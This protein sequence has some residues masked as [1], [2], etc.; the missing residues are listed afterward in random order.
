[1]GKVKIRWKA[2]EING[3]HPKTLSGKCNYKKYIYYKKYVSGDQYRRISAENFILQANYGIIPFELWDEKVS[4]GKDPF[5]GLS[6]PARQKIKRKMRKLKKIVAHREKVPYNKVTFS[7]RYK[8]LY[9][10]DVNDYLREK[11]KV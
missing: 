1:M 8:A 6:E 2:I 10:S 11:E 3:L 7:G 9:I 4:K 5:E